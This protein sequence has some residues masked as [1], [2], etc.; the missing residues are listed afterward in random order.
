MERMNPLPDGGDMVRGDTKPMPDQGTTT[1]L[2]GDTYGADIG[3]DAINRIGFISAYTKSD[4]I[5]ET[6]ND[7]GVMDADDA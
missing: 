6:D 3:C 2:N 7:E 1:G 5:F 4:P